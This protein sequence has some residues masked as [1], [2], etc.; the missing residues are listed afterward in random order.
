MAMAAH[1]GYGEI[2]MVRVMDLLGVTDGKDMTKELYLATVQACRMELGKQFGK[3]EE[4]VR[5]M[6]QTD[7]DTSLIY[8]GFI[9][10]QE[11]DLR[12]VYIWC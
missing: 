9:Q 1:K 5:E 2:K 12:C 10:F 6:I 4:A 8:C 7:A 11:T 3:P